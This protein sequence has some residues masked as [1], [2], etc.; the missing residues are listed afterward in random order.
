[1]DKIIEALSNNG[2]ATADYLVFAIY[3]IILVSMGMF[4]SRSKKGEER[5]S[6]D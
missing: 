5:S 6:T 3:I 1:M 4:L 2:F